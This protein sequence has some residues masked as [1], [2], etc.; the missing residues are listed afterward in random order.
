M[1]DDFTTHMKHV[2]EEAQ[3]VLV[4]AKEE[5]KCYAD[6]HRGEPPK[7]QVGDKVWLKTEHL[8]LS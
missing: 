8:K 2:H 4:K 1:V 7:Y 5:I 3:L 6:Y